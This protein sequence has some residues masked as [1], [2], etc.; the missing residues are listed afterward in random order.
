MMQNT[1]LLDLLYL[2]QSSLLILVFRLKRIYRF[3]VPFYYDQ[4]INLLVPVLLRQERCCNLQIT[5]WHLHPWILLDT[6]LNTVWSWGFTTAC[7]VC[8]IHHLFWELDLKQIFWHSAHRGTFQPECP[9]APTLWIKLKTLVLFSCYGH[10]W[11]FL[12]HLLEPTDP[13]RLPAYDV[14]GK[15]FIINLHFFF[16]I[17]SRLILSS[18]AVFY[19]A[20]P[21]FDLKGHN[22]I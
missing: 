13:S 7:F 18:A 8:W 22:L 12:L 11:V 6:W 14:S 10:I 21:E 17:F 5:V 2:V 15:G 9:C 4:C 16:Q 1:N 3:F 20:L 19:I